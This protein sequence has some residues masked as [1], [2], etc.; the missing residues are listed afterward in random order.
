MIFALALGK[1]LPE[2][3]HFF[4]GMA[5]FLLAEWLIAPL[6][7]PTTLGKLFGGDFEYILLLGAVTLVG[8]GTMLLPDKRYR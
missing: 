3:K 6:S 8:L 2:P 7:I 4:A 5:G 1:T